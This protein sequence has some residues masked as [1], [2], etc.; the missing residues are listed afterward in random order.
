M[1][2]CQ[3]LAVG[4]A[5]P[6]VNELQVLP[7]LQM[8]E[9]SNVSLVTTDSMDLISP[10]SSHFCAQHRLEGSKRVFR[11]VSGRARQQ[12]FTASLPNNPACQ[13]PTK[14]HMAQQ[15]QPAWMPGVLRMCAGL[16]A[17]AM[18]PCSVSSTQQQVRSRQGRQ[19]ACDALLEQ[20]MRRPAASTA[21]DI[22][23]QGLIRQYGKLEP[24]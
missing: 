22:S 14:R 24:G 16:L 4:H 19:L 9:A 6:G 20:H 7:L 10:A 13:P 23:R 11:S 2:V 5:L 18:P 12:A 15:Q 8:D 21:S 17:R 3:L 1:V